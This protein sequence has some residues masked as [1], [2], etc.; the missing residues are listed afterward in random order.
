MK[1]D[2]KKLESD[3]SGVSERSTEA[4]A[5]GRLS[6]GATALEGLSKTAE[7]ALI[8][9]TEKA[10]KEKTAAEVAL[11]KAPASAALLRDAG[12]SAESQVIAGL[13]LVSGAGMELW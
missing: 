12:M 6:G 1:A 10:R 7:A 5:G 11:K 8:W 9:L 4:R 3:P 2:Q 13:S